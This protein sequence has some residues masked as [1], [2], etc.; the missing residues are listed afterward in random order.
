MADDR[1]SAHV[2]AAL[3]ALEAAEKAAASQA[4][5]DPLGEWSLAW[6][7][8]VTARGALSAAATPHLEA[9]AASQEPLEAGDCAAHLR[10]C[11]WALDTIGP[12][13]DMPGLMVA[14]AYVQEVAREVAAITAKGSAPSGPGTPGAGSRRPQPW[15]GEASTTPPSASARHNHRGPKQLSA[16]TY[17][18]IRT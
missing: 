16:N 17:Q 14:K 3:L 7:G 8:V 1:I 9:Q 2:V 18:G 12:Q 11:A 5:W 15:P 6:G 4:G 10:A 13:A